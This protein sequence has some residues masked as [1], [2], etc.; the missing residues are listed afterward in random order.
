[1]YQFKQL[2]IGFVVTVPLQ[3]DTQL[4]HIDEGAVE[5]LDI[6]EVFDGAVVFLHASSEQFVDKQ[7]LVID[8]DSATEGADMEFFADGVMRLK[9]ESGIVFFRHVSKD[10]RFIL[11]ILFLYVFFRNLRGNRGF[12]RNLRSNRGFY[13]IAIF[14]VFRF[15]LFI[16]F[17]LFFWVDRNFWKFGLFLLIIGICR[18]IV[19]GDFQ[20]DLIARGIGLGFFRNRFFLNRFF[21]NR[22]FFDGLHLEDKTVICFFRLGCFLFSGF[23]YWFGF[24]FHHVRIFRSKIKI[25]VDL[26]GFRFKFQLRFGFGL[27]FWLKLGF[28]LRFWLE[29][30][31]GF[32]SNYYW[33]LFL[34]REWFF[35]RFGS[36]FLGEAEKGVDG[37]GVNSVL[38]ARLI[39]FGKIDG[40]KS[41]VNRMRA[42]HHH[43]QI[44]QSQGLAISEEI[45]DLLM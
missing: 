22:Y 13:S 24:R 21:L 28:R 33:F 23:F 17:L 32:W 35:L 38:L 34:H 39:L 15:L 44:K 42:V 19:M 2:L 30:R 20:F 10:D 29:L 14:N 45:V 36:R 9:F 6:V 4:I 40:T 7:E 43:I 12:F 31:F 37:L 11:E 27:G 16:K 25:E 41:I 26:L 5:G 8:S 3:V 18:K 1:M